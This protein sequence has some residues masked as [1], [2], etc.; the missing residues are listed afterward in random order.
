MSGHAQAKLPCN[1]VKSSND[2]DAGENSSGTG[3]FKP[4]Q[5]DVEDKF[6]QYEIDGGEAQAEEIRADI[7]QEKR[8]QLLQDKFYVSTGPTV[9]EQIRAIEDAGWSMTPIEDRSDE[10][11]LWNDTK[12]NIP[13]EYHYLEYLKR[14]G[15]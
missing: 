10:C 9:T 11:H 8:N 12:K 13:E 6:L 2:E 3:S 14:C 5:N 7:L 1:Q 4:G 15:E